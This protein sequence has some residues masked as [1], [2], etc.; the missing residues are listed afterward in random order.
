M[1]AFSQLRFLFPDESSIWQYD[2]K[3]N[4]ILALPDNLQTAVP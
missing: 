1:N 3:L 2:R 4:N